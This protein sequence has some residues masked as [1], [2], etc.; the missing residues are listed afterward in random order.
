MD[1]RHSFH[2]RTPFSPST[3][4]SSISTSTPSPPPLLLPTPLK[5]FP[6]LPVKRL[7]LEEL[8]SQREGGLYFNCDYK[9]HHG[10]KYA[11]KVFLLIEDNDDGL[12]H[13]TS[14]PDLVPDTN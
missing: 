10:H 4:L 7:F 6:S 12:Q 8:A 9:F 11:S 14:K 1:N 2:D 5:P 13:I 3:T